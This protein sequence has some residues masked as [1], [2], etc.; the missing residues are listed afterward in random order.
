MRALVGLGIGFPGGPPVA[1]TGTAEARMVA[2]A[3]TAA[4][5][6]PGF[7]RYRPLLVGLLK[8]S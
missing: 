7:D 3:G 4:R 1:A 6:V 8:G 2:T 5:R